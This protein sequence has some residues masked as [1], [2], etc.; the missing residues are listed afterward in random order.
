MIITNNIAEFRDGWRVLIPV[1]KLFDIVVDSGV[2]GIRKPNPEIFHLAMKRLGDI[3][4]ERA[5]F[6]DDYPTNIS[7]AT[8][9]GMQGVLVGEDTLEA[10]RK[11]DKIL[12]E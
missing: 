12:S 9:L 11:L 7:V 6:L 1:G 10:I 5:V 8:S 3:A 2:E 4:P